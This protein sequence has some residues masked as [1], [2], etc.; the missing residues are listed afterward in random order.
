MACQ[1][2]VDP[3]SWTK[4]FWGPL[5]NAKSHENSSSKIEEVPEGRRSM[6]V[7]NGL[8]INTVNDIKVFILPPARSFSI[9]GLR[10]ANSK[11][12]FAAGLG[13]LHWSILEGEL[14]HLSHFELHPKG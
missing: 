2:E 7:Q 12:S 1:N 13:L 9:N 6:I 3:K 4:N 8:I 11:T 14:R 10:L 5:Q